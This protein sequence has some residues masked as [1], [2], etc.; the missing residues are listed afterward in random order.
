MS[1]SNLLLQSNY[2]TQSIFKLNKEIHKDIIYLLQ[3][4]INFV[5]KVQDE[6][7]ISLND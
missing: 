3:Y 7:I 2:F 5:G 6:V 1:N 4:K